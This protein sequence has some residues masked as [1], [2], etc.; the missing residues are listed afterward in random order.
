M[1]RFRYA[2]AGCRYANTQLC[3]A[4]GRFRYANT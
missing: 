3:Y 2:E 4:K 1:T